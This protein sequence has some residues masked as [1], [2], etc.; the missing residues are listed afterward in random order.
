M[1]NP[2]SLVGKSYRTG[3]IEYRNDIEG[4]LCKQNRI[5]N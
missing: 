1:T 3:R 4:L 5:K 2:T